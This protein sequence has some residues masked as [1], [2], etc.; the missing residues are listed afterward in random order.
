[1]GVVPGAP[2]AWTEPHT[3]APCER[4]AQVM[5][6]ST[7]E[8]CGPANWRAR[9][10]LEQHEHCEDQ[11]EDAMTS[12]RSLGLRTA[13]LPSHG[14]RIRPVCSGKR[15]VGDD[16]SRPFPGAQK[17]ENSEPCLEV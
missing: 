15:Q 7:A 17:G 12:N 13:E 1:M 2:L 8:R 16:G 11:Y 5:L 9:T 3:A 10:L 4:G 6:V 14:W